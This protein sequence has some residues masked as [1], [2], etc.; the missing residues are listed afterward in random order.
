MSILE[1]DGCSIVSKS[2]NC[3]NIYYEVRIR[4]DESLEDDMGPLVESLGARG[5]KAE[6]VI[7]CCRTVKLMCKSLS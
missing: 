6:R 1:M 4:S 5:N 3:S 2:P 7:V